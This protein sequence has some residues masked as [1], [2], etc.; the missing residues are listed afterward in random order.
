[1]YSV[2][3]LVRS[4]P[5]TSGATY[6][7]N[8]GLTSRALTSS[9]EPVSATRGAALLALALPVALARSG[10]SRFRQLGS[11]VARKVTTSTAVWPRPNLGKRVWVPITR[12]NGP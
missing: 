12:V 10:T 8:Q 7:G 2:G 1:M 11:S 9:P 5:L 6:G 4:N 3:V